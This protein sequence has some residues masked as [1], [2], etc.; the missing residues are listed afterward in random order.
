M[1]TNRLVGGLLCLAGLSWGHVVQAQTTAS[2]ATRPATFLPIFTPPGTPSEA[3]RYAVAHDSLTQLVNATHANAG[4]LMVSFTEIQSSFGS[5]H[6][7]IKGYRDRER[8]QIVKREVV[9]QRFGLELTKVAYYDEK[10][11]LF[12]TERYENGQIIRL[13]LKQYQEPFNNPAATWVFVRGNYL[14]RSSSNA[15]NGGKGRSISYFFSPL[16]ITK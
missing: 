10:K 12:L 7:R 4:T 16:P 13:V 2:T 3:A 9:K 8:K 1:N 11:R 5:I 6:R 14:M 15:A